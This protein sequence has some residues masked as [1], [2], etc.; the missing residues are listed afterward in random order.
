[1]VFGRAEIGPLIELRDC[2]TGLAETDFTIYDQSGR[3]LMPAASADPI[4]ETFSLSARGREEQRNYIEKSIEKAVLRRGPSLF[5]G[6]MNQY[7]PFIPVRIADTALVLVGHAVYLSMK[8][9]EEFFDSKKEAYGLT[10]KERRL[11][12]KRILPKDIR[13]VSE[14]CERVH[15]LFNLCAKANY[16]KSLNLERYRRTMTIMELFSGIENNFTEERLFSLLADAV[17]FLFGGDTVSVMT[18]SNG[19]FVPVLA[20][21]KSRKKVE[22]VSLGY[23]YPSLSDAVGNRRPLVVLDALELLR[24]G[25]PE[26]ITSVHLFPLSARDET[27]GLLVVFNSRLT[28]EDVDTLSRMCRYAAFFMGA[29]ISR[30]MFDARLNGFTAINLAL[31]FMPAFHDPESLYESIVE[32]SSRMINAEKVSLMLPE[33]DRTELFIRAVKGI[34]K[35]IA[36]NIRVKVGEGIAGK[37][38]QEGKPLIVADIEKSLS[39]LTRPNYRTNSFVSIPLRIGDETIGV[40]NLADK[41]SGEVFSRLDMEFLRYFASFASVAIKGA[42]YFSVSEQMRT[43]SV[44]DPLTGLFN[45]RY[46]D[47]RLFE[48]L[49]RAMRY[50]SAFSLAIFDI[51]D[52]KLF[53]DTE[54]HVAGDEIL[55]TIADISRESLRAIDI[56]ARFGGEEFAVIMPQTEGEEAYLVVER[57][58]A[59][60]KELV[61]P[62]WKKFPRAK[63]TVS[64]GVASFATG[65]KDTKTLIRNADKALYRAKMNGKDRTAIWQNA[66]PAAR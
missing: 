54:G 10:G 50:D 34:N 53:N 58:R 23:D 51:D 38:Y 32:I 20:K 29:I 33:E 24:L 1:M 27:F 37:V 12:A 63:M 15:R 4:I 5:K 8:D 41:V 22:T 25:Y 61:P 47:D 52:F 28:G 59:N 21:G 3:L 13:R 49:Q 18:R 55:R 30:R 46:F 2:I 45:R 39:T 44:T 56:L 62:K 26:E 6:P 17:I 7:H 43:L 31:D 64:I 16:E 11:W 42:H 9:L 60:I 57:L 40:L 35:G 36:K 66:G 19:R 65:V 48:E 14:G